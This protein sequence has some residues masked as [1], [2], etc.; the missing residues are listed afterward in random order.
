M[1]R[2]HVMFSELFI[3][4]FPN[5]LN[6]VFTTEVLLFPFNDSCASALD[7]DAPFRENTDQST[8][9][10]AFHSPHMD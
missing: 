9:T 5:A 6:P 7:S 2:L 8:S 4:V 3:S 1:Q 10:M